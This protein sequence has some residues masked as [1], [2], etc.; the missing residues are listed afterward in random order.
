MCIYNVHVDM[1]LCS[2]RNRSSV[3]VCRPVVNKEQKLCAWRLVLSEE[4]KLCIY[5]Q[6][7]G[8]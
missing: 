7:C 8:F 6:I 5:M 4:L 3:C 1:T 2:V